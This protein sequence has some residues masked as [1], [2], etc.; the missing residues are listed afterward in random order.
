[1]ELACGSHSRKVVFF[2]W[3]RDKRDG[4]GEEAP[5]ACNGSLGFS[6][7]RPSVSRVCVMHIWGG[8]LWISPKG[9]IKV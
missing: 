1:V 2:L 4:N 8:E 6:C 3:G 7:L 9:M 5:F